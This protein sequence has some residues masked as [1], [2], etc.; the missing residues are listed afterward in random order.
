MHRKEAVDRIYL[1]RGLRALN[2]RK[3]YPVSS[4]RLWGAQDINISLFYF[5][6]LIFIYLFVCV[7]VF[8]R[9]SWRCVCRSED[10]FHEPVLSFYL[11]GSRG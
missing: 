10:N 8:W 1:D 4:L 6:F 3:L 5:N 11:V 9:I 7:R 2:F